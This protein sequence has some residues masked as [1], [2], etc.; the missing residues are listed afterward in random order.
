VKSMTV[1][2]IPSDR[3]ELARGSVARVR[4][5]TA[6]QPLPHGR[7]GRESGI[8]RL[9]IGLRLLIFPKHRRSRIREFST[10]IFGWLGLRVSGRAAIPLKG[11]H[12]T[13]ISGPPYREPTMQKLHRK[14]PKNPCTLCSAIAYCCG[15]VAPCAIAALLGR[16]LPR[17]GPL[18][19]S[20]GPFFFWASFLLEKKL[21]AS[22]ASGVFLYAR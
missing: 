18:V 12:K 6:R 21:H 22:A 17:L 5:Y 19:H 9:R 11:Q 4:L 13:F 8:S 3:V 2:A 16:F 1:T 15:A 7:I 20:S 14:R 10:A